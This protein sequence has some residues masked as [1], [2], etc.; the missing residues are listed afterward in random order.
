Q[1]AAADTGNS[2]RATVSA[3]G[4]GMWVATANQVRYVPFGNNALTPSTQVTNWQANVTTVAI[5]ASNPGALSGVANADPGQLSFDSG[6]GNQSNGIG[7]IDG[8]VQVGAFNAIGLEAPNAGLPT[9]AGQ[10]GTILAFPTARDA[11]NNFPL[12]N[13]IV[14]SPDGNT[15]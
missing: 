5:G 14:I 7:N 6:V 10:P 8:P 13:Q 3:D 15:I 1:I 4:L 9:V 12:S 2:V 11:S